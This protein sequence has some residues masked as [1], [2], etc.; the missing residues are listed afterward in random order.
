MKELTQGSLESKSA[1]LVS[2]NLEALRGIFPEAFTE[3]KVD[4]AVLGQL[5]GD[6]VEDGEERFGLSWHGKQQARQLALTPS[7]GTLRPCPEDSVDWDS[8]QNLMIEGDNLEVLKLM[9]KSYAGKVKLIYIDPPYNT[10]K[11]FVYRDDYRNNIQNYLELTA[12]TDEE[13]R[14]INSNAEASGRFH[15]N[16]LNMMYPRLRLARNLLRE[17]GVIFI[18][19]D[20]H[21]AHNLRM[22]MD[23]IFGEE[24][25]KNCII[26]RRG[27]KNVQ[28]QFDTID[29][30]TVGHEYVLMYA[31]SSLTRFRHLR[32]ELDEPRQGSW[33]NH[34]RGTDRPTMR[35]ELFGI[36]PKSGQWRWSKERSL[37]AIANYRRLLSDLSTSDADVSQKSIDEWYLARTADGEDPDLL[38]LSTGNKPEHY[39]PPTDSKLGS[40][41]WVDLS[42]RGTPE[43]D[44]LFGNKLFDNPKPTALVSRML[45]FITDRDTNDLVLDFFAGSCTTAQAVLELNREDGGNRRFIMVQLPE[46]TGNP[47][48]PTIA[49]IGKERIRRVIARLREE[50]PDYAGDL[51]FRV[52]KLDSTNIRAWDPDPEN[53][54]QTLLDSADHLREDRD[55]DDI[56]YELLLKLGLDL[57]VPLEAHT[58]AGKQVHS[59]GGGVLLACLASRIGADDVEPLAHGIVAWLEKLAPAGGTTC[60][61]R[62]SAFANDVVKTNFSAILE[63]HGLTNLRSI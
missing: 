32:I 55:E 23:E 51:G 27:I 7:T 53:L 38:R 41:L 57:C 9:Q 10:G 17:D 25:F 21:E 54:E 60:V 20:D 34:W 31:R 46:P 62:D 12:Q 1:D 35:Y 37:R 6:A 3:G 39:V 43:V 30:L 42:P 36:T 8:T 28:A 18:S 58:I 22:I 40:D 11:D 13:G 15:T 56:L 26:F 50:R 61:F 49:E 45:S 44:A 2:A 63:Q 16:W 14:K 52:F 59:V 29:A 4:L 33:N 48:F 19:I 47:E 24:T 5:L